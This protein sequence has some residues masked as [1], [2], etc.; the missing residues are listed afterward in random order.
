M[1]FQRKKIIKFFAYTLGVLIV[2]FLAIA[3]HVASIQQSYASSNPAMQLSRIDFTAPVDS[4]SANRI[5]GSIQHMESVQHA[6]FNIPDGIV[7][8]S[9]NPKVLSAE[10]V[11]DRIQQE[12]PFAA[13]RFVVD[14]EMAAS[15]CPI[16]GQN[17]IFTKAGN[18]LVSIFN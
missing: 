9:H 7:V 5:K 4:L 2:A 17:S 1:S 16:T 3:I 8:Y 14:A 12:F 13:K 11:Y 6:Y 15:G 10:T 18:L